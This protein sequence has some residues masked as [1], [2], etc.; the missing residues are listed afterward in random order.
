MEMR[1][2]QVAPEVAA[3]VTRLVC[4]ISADASSCNAYIVQVHPQAP[5][6]GYLKLPSWSNC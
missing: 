1:T 4:E 5:Q 6:S 2:H 3:G